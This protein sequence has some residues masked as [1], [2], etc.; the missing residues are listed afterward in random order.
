MYWQLSGLTPKYIGKL[1]IATV[2]KKL[3][4]VASS[5]WDCSFCHCAPVLLRGSAPDKWLLCI[6]F[7]KCSET[8]FFL[9][10]IAVDVGGVRAYGTCR[11]V[12]YMNNFC[13]CSFFFKLRFSI[14]Q[15]SKK[16]ISKK[17]DV[18]NVQKIA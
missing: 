14:W 1:T 12:P 3:I 9:F 18:Y 4:P 6:Y 17:I 7:D 10:P 15:F 16:Q 11:P 8:H 2:N 5:T 13:T